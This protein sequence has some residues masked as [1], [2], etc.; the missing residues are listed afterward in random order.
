MQSAEQNIVLP[1]WNVRNLKKNKNEL[2]IKR[3]NSEA[4]SLT[5][6]TKKTSPF[7]IDGFDAGIS[8]E[9]HFEAVRESRERLAQIER[10]EASYEITPNH[11]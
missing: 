11:S 10:E 1:V 8:T 3:R 9:E 2:I 5:G 4:F 6:I 7:D